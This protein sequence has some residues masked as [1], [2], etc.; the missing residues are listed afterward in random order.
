MYKS[1]IKTSGGHVGV[2]GVRKTCGGTLESVRLHR[3][4]E[5]HLLSG[6]PLKDSASELVT[7]TKSPSCSEAELIRSLEISGS[8]APSAAVKLS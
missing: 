3:H 2:P 8:L 5:E 4:L 7:V 6:G 1:L